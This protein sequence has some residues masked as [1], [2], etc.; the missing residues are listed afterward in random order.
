[1]K[2]ILR[3]L[4]VLLLFAGCSAE[5]KSGYEITGSIAGPLEEGTQVFLRKSDENMRA[6]PGD[7]A[8]ISNGTF[9]FSGDAAIPELR[10]IFIEGVNAGIPV[11]VENGSINITAHRDSLGRAGVEGTP[12]NAYYSDFV[13]GTRQLMD[14]RNAINSEM[15]V[16]MQSR[17]TANMN[18][19]RDEFFELQGSALDYEITFIAEHPDA[20]ISAMVLSRMLQSQSLP[21]AE[22]ASL[23]KGL[24]ESIQ[25]SPLGANINSQISSQ[26]RTSVGAQAPD[27]SAPT[28]SGEVLALNDI[29][30]KVTLVDFWA[31]WCR[32]CRAENPNIVK[33]YEKYKDKGLSILG[34]SLDR[35]A[36]D[37]INA[38]EQDGLTWHHVSNVRYFDEIAELYNVRAIPA[39]FILDENGVI[40][41]KNLRGESL[42]A[43]IAE[44]LP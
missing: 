32:P 10:Y 7:T 6:I 30:G 25:V 19:L 5:T 23:F 21:N 41:A 35:N 37:W 24:D 18:A 3:V 17:D 29:L 15:Q 14:R 36:A 27:F 39:S 38:I 34:V 9:S 28:P 20:L 44:L 26:E 1:M 42:E 4:P 13:E 2:G 22:I 33:V 31:A 16:A 11:F 43:K 8:L 12:Q 40:V